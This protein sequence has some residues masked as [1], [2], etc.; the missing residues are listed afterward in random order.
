MTETLKKI[1]GVGD[2]TAQKLSNG[3]ISD[4][5]EVATAAVDLLMELTGFYEKR[6]ASIREAARQIAEIQAEPLI[7]NIVELPTAAEPAEAKASE[8]PKKPKK[9]KKQGSK[10]LK[11]KAKKLAKKAKKA[12]KAHKKAKSK[13]KGKKKVKALKAKAKRLAKKAKKAKKEAKK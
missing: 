10:K 11:K 3:G 8:K 7:D 5:E 13:G 9:P 12:A 1:P 6:A 2:V 4:V